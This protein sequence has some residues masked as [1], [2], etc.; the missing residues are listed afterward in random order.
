MSLEKVIKLFLNYE[1]S[2][3]EIEEKVINNEIKFD[4][5]NS[6]KYGK[7]TKE[8]NEMYSSIMNKAVTLPYSSNMKQNFINLVKAIENKEDIEKYYP[9][10]DNNGKLY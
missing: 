10:Q 6:I 2:A 7:L 3:K 4:G 8:L 9:K 1:I 5:L